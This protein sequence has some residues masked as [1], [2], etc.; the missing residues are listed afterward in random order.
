[1][2]YA[3]GLFAAILANVVAI[4]LAGGGHGWITP[5]WVSWPLLILY[6]V[7]VNRTSRQSWSGNSAIIIDCSLLLIG[8]VLDY[9]LVSMTY[10]EGIQYFHLVMQREGTWFVAFWGVVWVFWQGLA[11]ISLRISLTERSRRMASEQ[12]MPE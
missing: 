8:M 7:T 6:P 12:S 4:G 5:F 11:L 10:S 9:L 3:L 2:R 1:M